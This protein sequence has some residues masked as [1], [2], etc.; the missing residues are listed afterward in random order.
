M[1]IHHATGYSLRGLP[2]CCDKTEPI[3]VSE[4]SN[5]TTKDLEG[6]GCFSREAEVNASLSTRKALPAWKHQKNF[7]VAPFRRASRGVVMLLKF[8]IMQN[9]E[10]SVISEINTGA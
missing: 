4:A 10:I 9:L 1:I 5:S 2:L 7:L 6:S 3:P 8:L